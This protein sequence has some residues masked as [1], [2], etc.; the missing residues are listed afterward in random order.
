MEFLYIITGVLIGIF[1]VLGYRKGLKD[2]MRLKEGKPIEAV[3]KKKRKKEY[4][5][6]DPRTEAILR[7]IDSYDGTAVGQKKID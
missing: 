7:N 6:V 5:E 2:G 3:P 4:A 1:L